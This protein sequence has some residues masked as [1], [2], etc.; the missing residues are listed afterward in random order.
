MHTECNTYETV[1]TCIT[2]Q[3]SLLQYPHD[4]NALFKCAIQVETV[5]FKMDSGNECDENTSE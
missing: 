1:H 3:T 5:V 2:D 4:V